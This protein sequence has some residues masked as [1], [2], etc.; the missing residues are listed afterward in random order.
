MDKVYPEELREVLS[1]AENNGAE[2]F[3]E[4]GWS[5]GRYNILQVFAYDYFDDVISIYEYRQDKDM[6]EKGFLN[7]VDVKPGALRQVLRK[8]KELKEAVDNE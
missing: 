1:I 5:Y 6:E 2:I 3:H 7:I 8:A 4:K